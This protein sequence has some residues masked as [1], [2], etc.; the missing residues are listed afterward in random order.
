MAKGKKSHDGIP[1]LVANYSDTGGLQNST[2]CAAC[3]H[4][5]RF[6]LNRCAIVAGT[7]MPTGSSDFFMSRQDMIEK[8]E[9]AFEE[10][11][12]Q[13]AGELAHVGFREASGFKALPDNKWVAWWT[14][15][16]RDNEHEL[17]PRAA[18]DAYITRL[19]E[20]KVPYPELRWRHHN[21]SLGKAEWVG[22]EGLI[23]AAAGAW[24]TD[25]VGQKFYEHY[26]GKE[27]PDEVSHGFYYD[28]RLRIGGVYWHYNTFEISPL[29][30][31]RA[32]NQITRFT[33]V[34]EKTM[35]ETDL[36]A[37]KS[38]VGE[39]IAEAEI[40]AMAAA[41]KD[42]AK[43]GV[44]FKEQGDEP[45]L[46][47]DTARAAVKLTYA[48]VKAVDAKIE[49][50]V[51]QVNEMTERVTALV[52]KAGD[53]PAEDTGDK[54]DKQAEAIAGLVTAVKALDERLNTALRQ[55]ERPTKS[56][57][58][59]TKEGD[60][61]AEFLSNN[62]AEPQPSIIG[63]MTKHTPFGGEIHDE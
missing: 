16:V 58:T 38:I 15:A 47:D 24:N 46:S 14:N 11:P 54:A 57:L 40:K 17:F 37:L 43:L 20:G 33:E 7:I 56:P 4:F 35:N 5:N 8:I 41:S 19:K 52:D 2:P 9:T 29:P 3:W 60:Q 50:V 55:G 32:A 45:T 53:T 61:E 10:A 48:A 1:Q 25:K 44:E 28:P 51:K 42:L 62:N 30:P 13:V 27:T 49:G 21:V 6:A 23:V 26:K 22:R 36:A 63:A 31:G 34:K 59:Q 18:H 12:L 39:D